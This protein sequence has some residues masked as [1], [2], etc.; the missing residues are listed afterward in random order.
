MQHIIAP[1]RQ[2]HGKHL[3]VADQSREVVE[4]QIPGIVKSDGI[5]ERPLGRDLRDRGDPRDR[6][7]TVELASGRIEDHVANSNDVM[8]FTLTSKI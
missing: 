3:P 6:A 5:P 8:L 4:S 2:T 7:V 1:R